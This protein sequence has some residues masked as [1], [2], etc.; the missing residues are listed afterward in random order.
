MNEE[1]KNGRQTAA[2]ILLGIAAYLVLSNMGVLSFFGIGSLFSWLFD[3]FFNLL[4]TG[5]LLL[6]LYWLTKSEKSRKP[7]VAGFL[8]MFGGVLLISQFGIFGLSFG[9]MFLPMWLIVIAFIILNPRDILP[10]RFNRDDD[11]LSD[12]DEEIQLV[13][14][15]GGGELNY[16]SDALV[17]G[18]IISVWGG[19]KVDF[20]D[21]EM[22]DDSM[23]LNLLC[24]MGGVEI[25]VPQN[26]EV[27][28]R[29]AV[30][31]MGGFGIKTRCIAEDLGLPRKKLIVKGLAL[32]GGGEIK[33]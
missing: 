6:G 32:M 1:E 26:W 12:G 33:N 16:T 10:R 4:P 14:F 31:I 17:G 23:E 2:Y 9:N 22:L 18:E 29:G 15:M 8:T 7:L 21:A 28:K 20:T 25:I 24:I 5:I 11:D 13:A 19:Y 30:C 27:E 3:A